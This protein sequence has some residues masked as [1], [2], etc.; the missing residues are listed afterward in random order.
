MQVMLWQG[1]SVV[2]PN[3]LLAYSLTGHW[4]SVPESVAKLVVENGI[5]I[6]NT[7]FSNFYLFY[8]FRDVAVLESEPESKKILSWRSCMNLGTSEFLMGCQ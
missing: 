5:C 2:F 6:L 3:S 4:E 1:V 7:L 8:S